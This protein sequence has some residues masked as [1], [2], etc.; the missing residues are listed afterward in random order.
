MDDGY[1]NIPADDYYVEA[2]EEPVYPTYNN[3]RDEK[4][5]VG[6]S[7]KTAGGKTLEVYHEDVGTFWRV[8]FKEGGELPRELKGAY[9][10]DLQ[11]FQDIE[12]YLARKESE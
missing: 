12:L 11:A 8:K 3:G 5:F 9:T 7:F 6:K 4:P 1:G 10:T 2:G